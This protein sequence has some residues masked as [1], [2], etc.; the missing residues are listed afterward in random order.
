MEEKQIVDINVLPNLTGT[1]KQVKWA[2]DIRERAL[3]AVDCAM[4]EKREWANSAKKEVNRISR[5]K[6][7]DDL[8]DKFNHM[9]LYND[10]A[11]IW[12]ERRCTMKNADSIELNLEYIELHYKQEVKRMNV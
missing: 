3:K 12:I 9:F 5:N 6:K 7:V 8:I 4:V 11:K 10:L 1:E 2:N